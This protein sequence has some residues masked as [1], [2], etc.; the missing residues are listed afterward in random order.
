MSTDNLDKVKTKLKKLMNLYEGAK[1]VNSEGEANAAAAAIQKILTEYNL[2]MSDIDTEEKTEKVIEDH[3]SYY[4]YKFIGGK[5]EHRLMFVIS[6]WNFCKCFTVG[7]EKYKKMCVMGKEENVTT[8]KWLHSFLCEKFVRIGKD[9]Y[10]RLQITNIGLD[11]YL[12]RYLMGCA[13]GLDAK[14][15]EENKRQKAEDEIYSAKVTSLV[16]RND[17]AIVEYMEDKGYIIKKGRSQKR[18]LDE[19]YHKG[20]TDGKNTQLHKPISESRETQVSNVKMLN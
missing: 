14:F 2:S 11:T 3:M 17:T 20:F 5:W 7:D 18:V 15:I 16:L 9:N 19:S 6:K 12:R 8:V 4:T 13:D 1:K 10:K